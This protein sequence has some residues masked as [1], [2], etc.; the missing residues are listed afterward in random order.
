[1]P[2]FKA[3][4]IPFEPDLGN[5][6]VGNGSGCFFHASFTGPYPVRGMVFFAFRVPA[7]EGIRRRRFMKKII[8]VISGGDLGDPAF[9]REQAAKA[10]PVAVICADGG[11]RH[12]SAAGIIPAL[13]VGDMDSLDPKSLAYYETKGCRIIRHSRRK[14][15]TDTEL[16]LH[17]AFAMAPTEVW[18]WGALGHRVDHTLAN[19]FLLV[20]GK[21]NG[22]DV[23]LID[24]WCEVFLIDRRTVITGEAGQTVSL[25]PFAGP[26]AG[27]TLT[28]FEF[29]LT[30]AV[31]E[32]GRP[33]GVSN[34]LTAEQGTVEVDSGR[35]LAVRYFRPGEFPGEVKG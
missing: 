22:T 34:R 35:L 10:A 9:L 28:G 23:K 7:G 29:P 20:Q 5:A 26:A 1:V 2:I 13:I 15:E 30:K 33:C 25:F 31:M 3:E 27:V 14:D 32:I 6:S 11:A 4:K 16:A 19:I 21:E 8:F 12:L 24:E 17:E 18:I